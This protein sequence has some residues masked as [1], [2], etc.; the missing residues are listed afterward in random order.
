MF[1]AQ[2]DFSAA[3]LQRPRHIPNS[4][5]RLSIGST[6]DLQRNGDE[7]K[8]KRSTYHPAPSLSEVAM[9]QPVIVSGTFG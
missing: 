9:I 5:H 7:T 2:W 4:V 3:E 6:P 1:P 8:E